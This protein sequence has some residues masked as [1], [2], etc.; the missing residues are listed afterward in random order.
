MG[1]F[2]ESIRNG[3]DACCVV[4]SDSGFTLVRVDGREAEFNILARQ[5]VDYDNGGFVAFPV[6]D[7]LD[8]YE[9]VFVIPTT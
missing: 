6:S 9:S 2:L 7:G 3:S 1:R 4:V 5:V 8:G